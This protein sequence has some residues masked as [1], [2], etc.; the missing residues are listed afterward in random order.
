M[1]STYG[2]KATRTND[3]NWEH[4]RQ[5]T[6]WRFCVRDIIIDMDDEDYQGFKTNGTDI[7]DAYSDAFE[8][9]TDVDEVEFDKYNSNYE[10]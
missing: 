5:I 8:D 10:Q 9:D 7:D 6:P 4:T 3:T 2:T 1:Y